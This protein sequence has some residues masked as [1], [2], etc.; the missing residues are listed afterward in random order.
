MP[1]RRLPLPLQERVLEDA[2]LVPQASTRILDQ[3]HDQGSDH[4]VKLE[5]LLNVHDG[6]RTASSGLKTHQSTHERGERS[7]PAYRST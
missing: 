4:L 6:S 7:C 1:V 3:Q 5:L 2:Q